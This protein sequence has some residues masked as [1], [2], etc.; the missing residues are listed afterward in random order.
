MLLL[1]ILLAD[2]A[3][4]AAGWGIVAGGIVIAAALICFPW[5]RKSPLADEPR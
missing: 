3:K 4:Q 2:A 5:K 1:P